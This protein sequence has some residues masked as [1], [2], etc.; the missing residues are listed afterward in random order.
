[1][2]EWLEA[3]KMKINPSKSGI[4][5]IKNKQQKVKEIPNAL[6]MPEVTSYRYLGVE[7]NQTI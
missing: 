4:L 7:V 1:M 3:N 2:T 6:D 5:R